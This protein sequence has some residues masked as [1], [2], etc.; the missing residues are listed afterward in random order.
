[1]R[2]QFRDERV[3]AVVAHPDD[4]ELLCAGTLVRARSEGAAVGICVLCQGEKGQPDPPLADLGQVRRGEMEAAAA[5]LGADLHLIGVPDGTLSRSETAA[6][7]LV[8]AYRQFRP[9]LVLAHSV[10]DYHADHRAASSLAEAASWQCA[11]RG[12]QTGESPMPEHPAVW[13]MDTV[14]MHGFSPGFYV[15]VSATAEL[16]ERMLACHT[17]Q[18]QRSDDADFAP[19]LEMMR[20]Q[21]TA[22]GRQSGVAAAEA[23]RMH[24]AFGRTRAW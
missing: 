4:A 7:L 14:G 8:D 24:D 19:L 13:W 23:F 5:I 20:A 16:K 11:S 21:Q 10:N 2:L 15:D 3:L 12:M 18:L 6:T 1:M 9:T 22:R 17:S